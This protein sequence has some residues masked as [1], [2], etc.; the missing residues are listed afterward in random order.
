MGKENGDLRDRSFTG[1]S[2]GGGINVALWT[3]G[4]FI[5]NYTH[6][7]RSPA[8]EELYNNGPHIGNVTFEI[9]NPDIVTERSNGFDFSLRHQSDRF[10]LSADTYYYRIDNF[11]FLNYQDA[12]GDGQADIRQWRASR[13]KS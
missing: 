2:G 6:S 8:L 5:A 10:K 3:G 11:V 4:A 1:F 9:G 13:W 7:F 12:D